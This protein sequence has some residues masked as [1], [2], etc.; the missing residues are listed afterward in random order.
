MEFEYDET[1]SR[2]NLAKHGIDFAAIQALWSDSERIEVAARTEGEPRSLV[3]GEMN[4]KM[5][6]AVVTE[7][8]GRIRIISARRSRPQEVRMYEG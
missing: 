5:W 7:R 6:S 2:A 8:D 4:G 1:K 3:I